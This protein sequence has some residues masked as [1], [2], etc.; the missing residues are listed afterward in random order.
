MKILISASSQSSKAIVHPRFG[1]ADYLVLF[2]L[3]NN[4]QQIFPNPAIQQSGGAGIAA[5]QFA[6]DQ[7]ANIVISS[8]FGPNAAEVLSAA[9]IKMFL[10]TDNTLTCEET[11]TAYQ[12][13]DLKE[14]SN[15]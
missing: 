2:D 3:E 11:I 10:F 9:G 12:N 8:H 5:A 15:G 6:A 1:R 13:G 4:S 14:F 7:G